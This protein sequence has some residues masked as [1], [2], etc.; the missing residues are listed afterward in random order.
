[1]LSGFGPNET[2]TQVA[3]I[4]WSCVGVVLIRQAC[5]VDF[6]GLKYGF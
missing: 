1:M 2:P 4:T 6:Q 3:I 5:L